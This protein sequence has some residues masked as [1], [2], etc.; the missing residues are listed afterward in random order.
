MTL[1]DTIRHAV[2]TEDGKLA[3]KI[4]DYLRGKG[5]NYGQVWRTVSNV[6]GI[7][8]PD[9]DALLYEGENA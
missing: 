3:V 9:W 4:S 2:S 5:M 6:T 8:G 7:D 1:K